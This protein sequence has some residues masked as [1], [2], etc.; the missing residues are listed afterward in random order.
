ME[1][2]VSVYG[3]VPGSN[4]VSAALSEET[5]TIASTIAE[6]FGLSAGDTITL[7][8]PYNEKKRYTFSINAIYDYNAGMAIFMPWE[9]YI[10][11]F[12]ADSA[13]FTGYFSNRELDD[14]SEDAIA[15]VI[16][17]SDLTKVSD[18]LMVSI[19]EMMIIAEGVGII[20]FLLLM[21]IM[22]KQIIEKNAMSISITK[23][24]GFS[25]GEIGGLYLVP[26][27]IVVIASLLISIPLIDIA[28]RWIFQSYL[29]TA[30][31]G[32]IPF[33]M[34]GSCYVKMVLLGICCYALIA[35]IQMRK[36]SKIPKS[37]ALKNME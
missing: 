4:Y 30:V 18:Q 26:T 21:Y 19:G 35:A 37:D 24:L 13:S 31:T 33:L 20:L 12:K 11:V 29:Y 28:L 10:E 17:V 7:K 14:L 15:S 27:S 32:Y 23:I 1:D 2:T 22:S 9:T 6:K 34:S 16:T 36:I 25:N 3:I 5:V 8:D